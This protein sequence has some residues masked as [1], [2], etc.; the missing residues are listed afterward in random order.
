MSSI[1]HEHSFCHPDLPR[2]SSEI[3][4]FHAWL[5]PIAQRFARFAWTTVWNSVTGRKEREKSRWD[6]IPKSIEH[7]QHQ[8]RK[9]PGIWCAWS[10]RKY[11]HF[12]AFL[13]AFASLRVK[14]RSIFPR[15]ILWFHHGFILQSIFA[16][17]WIIWYWNVPR[18]S[19]VFLITWGIKWFRKNFL[20]T[21]KDFYW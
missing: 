18:V 1:I 10:P 16:F 2:V 5:W 20:T 4:E 13:P 15:H 19:L 14:E 9:L 8:V 3:I 11:L 6:M 21:T 17:L 12:D 7:L